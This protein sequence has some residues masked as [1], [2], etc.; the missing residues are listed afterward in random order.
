[1]SMTK[2]VRVHGRQVI[3]SRGNLT[4]E[5]EVRLVGGA[6]GSAIVPSGAS[7]GEHE[8]WE[9]RNGVKDRYAGKGVS[10]AVGNVNKSIA[11]EIEGRDALDQVGIDKAMI[12]LDGT[13]N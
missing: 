1:M 7:T 8:A 11:K 12:A 10:K 4:V 13:K 5:A 2:I 9:L 3:D 6:T